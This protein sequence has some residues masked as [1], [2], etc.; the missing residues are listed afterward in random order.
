MLLAHNFPF[1]SLPKLFTLFK[2]SSQV[3]N[4]QNHIFSYSETVCL[5]FM[6][7]SLR[8]IGQGFFRGARQRASSLKTPRPSR[9]HTPQQEGGCGF[10]LP[11]RA[12]M[13]EGEAGADLTPKQHHGL[14]TPPRA[15]QVLF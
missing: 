7:S 14:C 4:S 12:V 13:E 11:P 15:D 8:P 1:L 6:L 5:S 9:R 3:C 10:S 2:S